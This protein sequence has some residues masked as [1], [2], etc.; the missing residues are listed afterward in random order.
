MTQSHALRVTS[1]FRNKEEFVKIPSHIACIVLL[2]PVHDGKNTGIYSSL[3]KKEYDNNLTS[4]KKYST[5]KLPYINY[6]SVY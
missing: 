1:V 2:L 4:L 5:F 6:I 3:F